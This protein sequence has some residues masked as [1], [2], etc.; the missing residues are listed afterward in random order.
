VVRL[1]IG[2]SRYLYY[3]QRASFFLLYSIFSNEAEL[4]N[5]VAVNYCALKPRSFTK[6]LSCTAVG[7]GSHSRDYLYGLDY[8]APQYNNLT[9]CILYLQQRGLSYSTTTIISIYH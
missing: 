2:S 5:L 3:N 1:V 4:S 9:C 7:K 6:T 8:L